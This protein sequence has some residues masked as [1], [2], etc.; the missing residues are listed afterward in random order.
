MSDLTTRGVCLAALLILLATPVTGQD[1]AQLDATFDR[2]SGDRPGCALGVERAGSPTIMRAWGLAELEHRVP[3][4][5]DTIYEAGS[6]SKQ[7]TA[8]AILLLADDGLLTLDDDVRRWL[9]ELPDYG[10][11]ITIRHLLNH[12]SGL[13][14]WGAMVALEGWPRGSRATE[15]SQV[16]EVVARQGALNFEPGSEWLYSNSGYNLAAIIVARVSAQSFADFTRGRLFVPLGMTQTRWRDDFTAVVPGRAAAYAPAAGGYR[17]AM[18]FENAHGNGGLLTT[19]GDLLIW[20]RALSSGHANLS[21]RLAEVGSAGGRST[22]YGLGLTRAVH[23]GQTEIAHGGA[24]GGYRSWLARYPERGLSIALL[25]NAADA[26]PEMLGRQVASLF[27]P[28]Q[29]EQPP[30]VPTAPVPE[31]LFASTRT[32]EPLGLQMTPRGPALIPGNRLLAPVAPGIWR[33]GADE[34]RFQGDDR[35]ER[36]TQDG[37]RLIYERR[38]PVAPDVEALNAYVGTYVSDEARARW[39]LRVIEGRLVIDQSGTPPVILAPTYQDAFAASSFSVRFER[40]PS[41]EVTTLRVNAG[42]ARDVVFS[43]VA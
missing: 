36:V 43:R 37:D 10:R 6:V 21:E 17:L 33:I 24:T 5:P 25:C 39:T 22:H 7:F 32:G 41:G 26:S 28:D 23:E 3:A 38:D 8:A 9:P 31:G 30:Y 19:V 15:Q 11:T 34:L 29:P 13:R 16:L 35:F 42:R 4:D 2:W 18:P 27:L 20:N 14:D 40:A 12:T 1:V